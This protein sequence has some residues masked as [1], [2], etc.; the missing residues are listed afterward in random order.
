MLSHS[1]LHGSDRARDSTY[2]PQYIRLTGQ[3]HARA[4]RT[5]LRRCARLAVTAVASSPV[6]APRPP[7]R[8]ARQPPVRAYSGR[9]GPQRP[10]PGP[11]RALSP[12]PAELP[13]GIAYYMVCGSISILDVDCISASASLRHNFCCSTPISK[14]STV[15]E[16][17]R[18]VVAHP[19]A[20]GGWRIHGVL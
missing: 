1:H 19:P 7:P 6:R 17:S 15:F 14:N 12:E 5:R 16:L 13:L 4:F 9:Q 8:Q 20:R 3:S 2:T 11:R 10:W 18:G